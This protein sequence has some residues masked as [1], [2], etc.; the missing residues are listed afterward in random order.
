MK[1]DMK[2]KDKEL[3]TE[4]AVLAEER[5]TSIKVIA[6]VIEEVFVVHA[7]LDKKNGEVIEL[8]KVANAMFTNGSSTVV[9]TGLGYSTSAS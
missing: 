9:G 1:G 2:K 3:I 6:D 4:R 7:E 8:Q 5:T